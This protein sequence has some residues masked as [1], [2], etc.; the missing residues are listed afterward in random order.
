M[1]I[2]SQTTSHKNLMILAF[3]GAEWQGWEADSAP[4]PSRAQNSEPHSQARVK[5]AHFPIG[6]PFA[7][8]RR[9]LGLETLPGMG[10]P[11]HSEGHHFM[12]EG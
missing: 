10:G 7:D 8:P 3:I 12:L 1:Y 9:E 6:A 5:G 4:P 11:F 2:I